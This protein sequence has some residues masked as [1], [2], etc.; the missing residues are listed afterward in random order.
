MGVVCSVH[1]HS[2]GIFCQLGIGLVPDVRKK[3]NQPLGFAFPKRQFGKTEAI[4]CSGIPGSVV[5][6]FCRWPPQATNPTTS[7][8]V[9]PV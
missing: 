6:K 5:S 2:D 4:N 8:F 9:T 1:V 7:H 3:P